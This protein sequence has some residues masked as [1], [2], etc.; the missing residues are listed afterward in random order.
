M[1]VFALLA[2]K[3]KATVDP[4]DVGQW[5]FY[6]V[7]TRVLNERERS[8]HSITLPSLRKLAQAVTYGELLGAVRQ[9]CTG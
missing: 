9:A 2:H 4:M 6:V 3:D 7:P 8:Q 5:E 1:Y